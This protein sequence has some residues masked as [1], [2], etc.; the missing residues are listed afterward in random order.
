M[1]LRETPWRGQ[2][3]SSSR[4]CTCRSRFKCW[5]SPGLRTDRAQNHGAQSALASRVTSAEVVRLHQRHPRSSGP[6]LKRV[7]S[8]NASKDQRYGCQEA[9][10]Q[11]LLA[12]VRG[13]N[14]PEQPERAPVSYV[15]MRFPGRPRPAAT[16]TSLLSSAIHPSNCLEGACS[17]PLPRAPKVHVHCCNTGLRSPPSGSHNLK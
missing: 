10:T 15:A 9:V 1:K 7:R 12:L 8:I 16:V 2:M 13:A 11:P 6:P 4:G 14:T 3:G 5:N 17:K